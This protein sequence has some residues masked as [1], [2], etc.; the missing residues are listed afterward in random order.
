M[1]ERE[2][3]V[4]MFSKERMKLLGISLSKGQKI[5]LAKSLELEKLNICLGWDAATDTK[6]VKG[7]FGKLRG[8]TA[9]SI[10]CDASAILLSEGKLTHRNN[11]IYFGNTSTAG[12][13]HSGDNL[14]GKG[15][16]D[17]EIISVTLCEVSSDV[18][19]LDFIVNIYN[20]DS[21]KQD[22]GMI[23][24]AYIRVVN[25]ATNEELA[26][27]SLSDDYSGYR[28]LRIGSLVRTPSGWDFQAIGEGTIDAS[29]RDYLSNYHT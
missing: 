20:A 14:T 28:T 21:R 25:T 8:A 3:S 12:V 7:F 15:R 10:D 5:N 23:K 4:K 13:A 11:L 24:N 26:R 9:Q 27:Y 29:I 19:E 2:N 17:D 18:T 16:G 6:D 1:Y 22:F